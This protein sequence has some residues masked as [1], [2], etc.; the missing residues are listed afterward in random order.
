ML[1]C[2]WLILKLWFQERNVMPGDCYINNKQQ[3]S[4]LFNRDHFE[5]LLNRI[6][7]PKKSESMR[8]H[9]SNSIEN[10]TPL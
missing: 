10:A 3:L 1:L 6:I 9:S 7:L 2:N 8:P 5:S 4:E